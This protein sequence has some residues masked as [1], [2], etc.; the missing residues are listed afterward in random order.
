MPALD[1]CPVE[2]SAKVNLRRSGAACDVADQGLHGRRRPG[3][4][5]RQHGEAVHRA[6][7]HQ[8]GTTRSKA[9]K[10]A[11]RKARRVGEPWRRAF[12]TTD[13]AQIPRKLPAGRYLAWRAREGQV[14]A[15]VDLHPDAGERRVTAGDR[16]SDQKIAYGCK[17][18]IT[19]VHAATHI[20][21]VTGHRLVRVHLYLV[22]APHDE[23]GR[24]DFPE[25]G[26][27]C[28]C[29]KTSLP[30][31]RSWSKPFGRNR[32]GSDRWR[33]SGPSSTST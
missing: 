4:D 6:A 24:Y 23:R 14:S 18:S 33:R 12:L 25:P 17:G 30:R 5:V 20:V 26:Q 27:D 21:A 2:F 1:R 29:L 9:A 13:R 3:H 19:A 8:G 16:S 10:R 11:N 31:G 32:S 15:A 7:G 28:R 22:V